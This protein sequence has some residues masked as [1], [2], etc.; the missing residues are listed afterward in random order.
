M[1]KELILE[2][3]KDYKKGNQDVTAKGKQFLKS[4]P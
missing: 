3:E 4:Y 2:R 1:L